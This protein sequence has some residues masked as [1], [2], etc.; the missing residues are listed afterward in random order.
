MSLTFAL[1]A[2]SASAPA[3]G[4]LAR[5]VTLLERAVRLCQESGRPAPFPLM[6]AAWARRITWPGV[7]PTPCCCC[8]GAGTGH[9]HRRWSQPGDL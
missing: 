5:A 7:A 1:W 3:H 9:W 6:A 4:D 8:A 2:R